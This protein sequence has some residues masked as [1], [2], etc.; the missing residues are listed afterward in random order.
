MTDLPPMVINGNLYEG[1]GNALLHDVVVHNFCVPADKAKIQAWL[2]RTFAEPS[3][4]AVRYTALGAQVFLGIA[5]IGHL[6]NVDGPSAGHGW[7]SEIDITIWLLAHSEQDD[8]PGVRWIPAYLFVDSGPALVSGREI[9]GFPK[10]LGRFY[11]DPLTPDCGAARNFRAEGWVIDPR[12]PE[13]RAHWATMFEVRPKPAAQPKRQGPLGSL[14][15]LA[16]LVVGRL[17]ED[18]ADFGGRIATMLHA[19]DVTMAFLKQFP[20]TQTPTRACY[21]AVVEAHAKVKA[22]RGAGLTDDPYEVRIAT[23]ASHPFLSELGISSDWQDVGHGLWMDFDFEQQLGQ[24][25][26]RAPMASRG[27][28]AA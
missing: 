26:W 24:E 17:T 5:E 16:G 11:F 8:G 14:I 20:D 13:N 7:T 3:G 10:Q 15:D 28:T 27:A 19:G 1:L 18:M 12:G 4:G 25:L 9:W 2:D 22:L 6:T 23:F 21:Q